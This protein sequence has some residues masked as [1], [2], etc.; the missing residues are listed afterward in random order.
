MIKHIIQSRDW[1]RTFGIKTPIFKHY[2]R[3]RKYSVPLSQHW[4]ILYHCKICSPL[5]ILLRLTVYPF[6][7][8]VTLRKLK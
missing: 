1:I 7:Y 8:L 4:D 3:G 5:I 2:R 6:Y